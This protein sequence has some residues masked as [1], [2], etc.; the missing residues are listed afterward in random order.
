MVLYLHICN[1]TH[2]ICTYEVYSMER[3]TYLLKKRVS[4]HSKQ[5]AAKTYKEYPKSPT[6]VTEIR[7]LK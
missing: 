4:L 2:L 3:E 5:Q 6:F 7:K 1:A